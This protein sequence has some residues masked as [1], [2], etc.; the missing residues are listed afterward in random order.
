MARVTTEDCIDKVPNRFDLVMLAAYRAREISSGEPVTVNRDNDKNPVVAL[1]EIA[2]ETQ[3]A[4]LT[5]RLIAGDFPSYEPLIPESH[6]NRLEI[7]RSALLDSARRLR[8]LA[9]DTNAP[10]RME[11]RPDSIELTVISQDVGSANEEIDASFEGEATTVAFNPD[12]LI[13]GLEAAGGDT[14]EIVRLDALKP[15]VLRTPG[16]G[17]F[18]YLLMPVRV[19]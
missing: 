10:V 4:Q 11:L 6:D 13:E 3:S 15:A 18:L 9:R 2:E 8:L 7:D 14:V 16:Y 17:E 12:Y 1:R 19:S 5:C